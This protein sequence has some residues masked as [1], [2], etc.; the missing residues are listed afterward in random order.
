MLFDV[1]SLLGR[2]AGLTDSR[3]R[4]GK[5]YQLEHVLLLFILAKLCGA[6]TPKAIGHWVRLRKDCL[7]RLLGLSRRSVPHSNTYRRITER[8]VDPD[9]LER[10]MKE[11][12]SD[13]PKVGKSVLISIDGKVMRGT[14]SASPCRR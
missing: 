10:T 1:R 8:V 9:E 13:L 7:I 12:F 14:I 11:F 6:D 3:F 4:R 2:L 5:R